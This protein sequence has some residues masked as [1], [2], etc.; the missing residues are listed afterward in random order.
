MT[1]IWRQTF[2]R[3]NVFTQSS[4]PLCKLACILITSLSM[5]LTALL[6]PVFFLQWWYRHFCVRYHQRKRDR[7]GWQAVAWW[8]DSVNQW[9]RC[10]CS[11]TGTC[12]EASAGQTHSWPHLQ[13]KIWYQFCF[14]LAVSLRMCFFALKNCSGEVYL[15]VARFKAGPQYSQQSQVN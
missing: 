12:P 5:E 6:T 4:V 13:I 3:L 8:P 14:Y 10:S 11:S 1:P 2:I 15:E 9:G 7:F